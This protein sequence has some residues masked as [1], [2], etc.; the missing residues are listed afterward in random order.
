MLGVALFF[1]GAV[2]MVNG[3]G[4]TGRIESRDLA[5]FNL[6]VGLLALFINLLGLQRGEHMADY[7]AVAGGLLFAFTYLYLAVV[8]WYGLKG[9]GFGWYCLFVAI[10]AL[11]FSWTASDPRL[12]T[13]WLLWSSLWFLFFLSLG[14]GRSLRI[15]PLYTV[16]IGV[17]TCW[18]PGT[19]MLMDA[20]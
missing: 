3:V 8:Q 6:L 4:L 2:L 10:S 9:V 16:L 18:L 15:L 5:P 11:A 20:W 1:I 7:F 12:V 13:L 17:L 14:L 19:L